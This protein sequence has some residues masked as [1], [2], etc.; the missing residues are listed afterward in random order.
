L[1]A[2]RGAAIGKLVRAMLAGSATWVD[3]GENKK[4]ITLNDIVIITPYNAQVFEIEQCL[5]GVRVG[6]VDKFQGQEAAIAIY[7][8][9]TSS[10]VD[11]PRGM[12][13]LYSL[14]RLNVA[15]SRAK[16]RRSSS[17]RRR[18][19]RQSAAC[20]DRFNW[21]TPSADFLRWRSDS[22]SSE[23]VDS[24]F[25]RPGLR[26]A[27]RR[28]SARWPFVFVFYCLATEGSLAVKRNNAPEHASRSAHR[29]SDDQGDRDT[30][31]ANS[32]KIQAQR[33]LLALVTQG[34]IT[35]NP[36]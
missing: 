21:Q 6:T 35:T 10:H 31:S 20:R 33:A 17:V 4:S 27:Y 22:L 15:I 26:L 34:G 13:F 11:A 24:T 16:A 23:P 32:S 30:L 7:S 3:R 25:D 29:P 18:S 8:T 2:R 1:L 14:N 28:R 5:P 12:E 9:A 36:R 19:S